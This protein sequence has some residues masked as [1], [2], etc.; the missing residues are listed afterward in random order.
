MGGL[1]MDSIV[2]A[3]FGAVVVIGL[4]LLVV[5]GMGRR[6]KK[7]NPE[8]YKNEWQHIQASIT[9]DNKTQQFA[10]IQADKLLDKAL[11][12]SGYAGN[13][14]AERMTSAS[15]VFSQ[16][17]AVW[18][19][20]KLRNRIAH[21]SSARVNERWVKKALMSYKKALSDVGAL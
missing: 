7:L 1:L 19:A 17:E 18:T 11:K 20:H 14:M 21:E 15:R 5:I 6:V 16:R 9:S 2:I 4:I 8:Y 13:T 3:L 10:I 12:E